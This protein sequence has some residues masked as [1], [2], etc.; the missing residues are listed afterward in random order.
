[1]SLE[2]NNINFNLVSELFI[3]KIKEKIKNIDLYGIPNLENLKIKIKKK[4]SQNTTIPH[5]Q[6]I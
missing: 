4:I 5:Q 2:T 6:R 3:D 1:M